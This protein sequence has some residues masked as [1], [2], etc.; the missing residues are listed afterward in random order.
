MLTI[1]QRIK[2]WLCLGSFLVLSSCTSTQQTNVNLSP[3][4]PTSRA[5]I[6]E[7]KGVNQDASSLT[8]KISPTGTKVAQ[9]RGN[10]ASVSSWDLSGAMAARSQRKSWT[11]S[12]NWTQHGAFA[13]QIRLFGPIGSGTVLI[14]K[15]GGVVTYKDG[16]KIASSANA[17]KLLLEKTG[18]R[19]PVSSLYYWVRGLP[20][21]GSVKSETR[22]NAGRLSVLRQSGYT[23]EF[24]EY[25]AVSSTVLPSRIKLQGNGVVIKLVIK[26]WRI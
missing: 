17:D 26:R 5:A 12:I 24:N 22:D 9:A 19:L 2:K 25:M 11:A 14:Q 23:I 20:A 8:Q 6:A 10:G 18:V 3:L 13:Y 4:P 7:R 21:P 15:Q 1:K 16:P